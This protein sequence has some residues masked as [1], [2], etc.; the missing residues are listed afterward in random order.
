MEP[1]L[2]VANLGYEADDFATLACQL[3]LESVPLVAAVVRDL[4]RDAYVP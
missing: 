4:Q 2:R 3:R 1:L